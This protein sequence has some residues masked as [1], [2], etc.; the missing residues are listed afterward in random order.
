MPENFSSKI[1]NE[2]RMSILVTLIYWEFQP[3]Q[4]VKKRNKKHPNWKGKVKK[5]PFANVI[6]LYVENPMFH[7][8]THKHLE[9]IDKFNKVAGYKINMK[10]QAVFL[11]INNT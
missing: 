7:I 11:Y 5:S 9:L 6:I 3:K 1:K 2:V 10:N 4:L 8:N